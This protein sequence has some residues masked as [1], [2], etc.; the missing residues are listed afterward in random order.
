MPLIQSTYKRPLFLAGKHLET[1]YPALFR[2][3][4]QLVTETERL[5]LPDGDFLDLDWYRQGSPSLMI[6]SHGLEGSSKSQY[7]RWMA[8]RLFTEGYDVLVWN[9]RGCSDTPNRLMRFYHSGDTQDLRT[10]LNLAV[11][12]KSYQHL[13]LVGFSVGG[14]ITLKYLGEQENDLD[15]RLVCAITFS[16]PTDL[17]AGAAHLAKWESAVYM[18]RFMQSL[19]RKVREKAMRYPTL[20]PEPLSGMRTFDLFDEMYTAPL[21]GFTN[22]REYWRLNSSRYYISKIKLPTLLVT[23]ANDPFLTPE[24]YPIEEAK[25]MPHF[26]LEIPKHG[27]HC[28]FAQFNNTGFYWSEDRC[29]EFVQQ[30]I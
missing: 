1:I 9:Y 15:S 7:A 26:S 16:V 21:H 24:C 27:G 5:E 8:K 28:G 22:A 19:K 23:A 20:D 3:E 10:M 11:F 14:N 25:K 6:L 17:T 13:V 29:V 2:P 12:P 18:N 4:A 30:Y